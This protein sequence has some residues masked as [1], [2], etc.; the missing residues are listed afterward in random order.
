MTEIVLAKVLYTKIE[1]FFSLH[2]FFRDRSRTAPRAPLATSPSQSL[3]VQH[4]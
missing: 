2:H 1:E 3:A 4:K